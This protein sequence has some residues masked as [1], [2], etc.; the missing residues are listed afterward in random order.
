M[1][2]VLCWNGVPI[3]IYI[4]TQV[5]IWSNDFLFSSERDSHPSTSSYIIIFHHN[6]RVRPEIY[7]DV[8]VEETRGVETCCRIMRA[9]HL[10]VKPIYRT[11]VYNLFIGSFFFSFFFF[12]P[13]LWYIQVPR[14]PSIIIFYS[15]PFFF[16]FFISSAVYCTLPM[17]RTCKVD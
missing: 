15:A 6:H 8:G 10:S 13:A 1:I 7:W 9:H 2:I 3:Y 4:Y 16:F 12:S 5:R 11:R 14:Y 17:P